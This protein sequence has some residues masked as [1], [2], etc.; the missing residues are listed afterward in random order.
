MASRKKRRA[1]RAVQGGEVNP[2]VAPEEEGAP[3]LQ[4]GN[5]PAALVFIALVLGPA[6]VSA[7]RFVARGWPTGPLLLGALGA[8]LGV[9]LV[10]GAYRLTDTGPTG[11]ISG[12]LR[13]VARLFIAA[14]ALALVLAVVSFVRKDGQ[15]FAFFAYDAGGFIQNLVEASLALVAASL[16]AHAG[17]PIAAR[18]GRWL[19][20][21]MLASIVVVP[22]LKRPGHDDMMFTVPNPYA[23]LVMPMNVALWLGKLAVFGRLALKR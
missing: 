21:A 20:F 6:T 7:A 3:R 11:P 5:G 1:Q 12:G 10:A 18:A 13:V 9:M 14:Y 4:R 15:G 23:S 22:L 19:G 16:L 8:M 17:S 2:Y